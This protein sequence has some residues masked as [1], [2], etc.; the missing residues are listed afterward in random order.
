[1]ILPVAPSDVF[2]AT[3]ASVVIAALKSGEVDITSASTSA[4]AGSGEALK[5]ETPSSVALSTSRSG[6]VSKSSV[7]L[8]V[9]D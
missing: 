4:G 1:M 6:G 3:G 2:T 5:E 8:P 9:M 7:V